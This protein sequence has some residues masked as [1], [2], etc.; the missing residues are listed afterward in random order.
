M[1]RP[2]GGKQQA[3]ATEEQLRQMEKQKQRK[4]AG[5]EKH[6]FKRQKKM[7]QHFDD[8]GDDLSTIIDV[9]QLNR[10]TELQEAQSSTSSS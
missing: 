5:L 2:K 3:L 10:P 9:Q 7:E 6:A 1:P 4:E 8:C